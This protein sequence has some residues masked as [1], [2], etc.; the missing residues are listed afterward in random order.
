MNLT[1]QFNL[2]LGLSEFFSVGSCRDKFTFRGV[3]TVLSLIP[4]DISRPLFSGEQY[5]LES[6]YST[7]SDFDLKNV[8][9]FFLIFPVLLESSDL[10]SVCVGSK[11]L[12]SSFVTLTSS[13]SFKCVR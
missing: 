7:G 6:Y 1:V 11:F 3:P 10:S 4:I 9:N 8:L 2:N 5:T 13:K 12:V